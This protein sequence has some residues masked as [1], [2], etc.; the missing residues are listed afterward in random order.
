[1][2]ISLEGYGEFCAEPGDSVLDVAQ[3]NNVP[4]NDS[5]G[6]GGTCGTCLVIVASDLS[7]LPLRNDIEKEMAEDRG[8]EANERQGCQLLAYDN[9]KVKLP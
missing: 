2:K 7:D 5:C 9:L 6:G 4:L 8:F 1:M 3:K